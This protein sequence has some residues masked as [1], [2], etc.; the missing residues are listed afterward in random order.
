[1][2]LPYILDLLVSKTVFDVWFK[3]IV[4]KITIFETEEKG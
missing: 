1:M 3:I 4:F 2:K